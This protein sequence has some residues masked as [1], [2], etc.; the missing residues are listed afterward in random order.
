[1]TESR[2]AADHLDDEPV[3]PAH[4][5]LKEAMAMRRAFVVQYGWCCHRCLQSFWWRDEE[6]LVL[7]VER[8][9]ANCR[10]ERRC[11]DDE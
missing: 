2:P 10:E 3:E 8:H 9:L 11:W 7:L 4:L 6:V 1:M 5:T